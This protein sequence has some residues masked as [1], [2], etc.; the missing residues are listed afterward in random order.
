MSDEPLAGL[1][2]LVDALRRGGVPASAQRVQTMLRAL[3]ETGDLY[4]SGRLTLCGSPQDIAAYDAVLAGYFDR[5]DGRRAPPP[6]P[7]NPPG[8]RHSLFARAGSAAAAGEGEPETLAVQ[9]SPVEVLRHRDLAEL[10]IVERAEANRLLALLATAAPERSGRRYR[11]APAGQLDPR[12]SARA[13]LRVGG[14]PARLSWR[15]RRPRPRR[16]VLL[17]DVS[18]SM[19][20]Y[21]DGLLRFAH[22][23]VRNRPHSTEAFALGTRL[24]RLT[25]ALG[26]PDPDAALRAAGALIPDWRGGT[27]LGESIG[28]F[29]RGYGHRGMARR[30]VVVVFSDGWEHGDAEPLRVAAQRLARLAHRVVWAT[31]HAARPGFAPLAGGLVAVLPHVDALLSGHSIAALEELVRE[32]CRA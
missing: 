5:G 7:W 29:L 24:T 25:A 13:I 28:G 12:R 2:D 32:V 22:A 21:A 9:A 20:P 27:R 18:G 30:A 3:A 23:A 15:A 19:A 16:V 1:V 4:W 17:I 26:T 8:V 11:A 14:E 10:S 6:R 31:P